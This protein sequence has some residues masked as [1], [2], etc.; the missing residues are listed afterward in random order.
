[1]LHYEL[2]SPTKNRTQNLIFVKVGDQFSQTQF[3]HVMVLM[4]GFHVF[5]YSLGLPLTHA[6]YNGLVLHSI[7]VIFFAF[8][9]LSD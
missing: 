7:R 1:M 2:M 8:F 3:L 4:L 6:A 9:L 5:H